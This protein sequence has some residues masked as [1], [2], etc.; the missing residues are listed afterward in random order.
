MALPFAT[1]CHLSQRARAADAVAAPVGH[2][3]GHRAPEFNMLAVGE[4]RSIR[5]ADLLGK[6]VIINFYC[7]CNFCSIVGE[8]WVKN[9]DKVGDVPVLAV[10]SNH[11]NYS[12]SAVKQYRART[13]WPWPILADIGS[14]TTTLFN[15]HTCPKLFVLD[16]QGIIR[17]ASGEGA[18]D[19][20]ALVAA[21]VAAVEAVR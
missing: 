13:G 21:A 1:G 5:S 12:P 11:W 18:A 16:H 3:V 2:Q 20:K 19:E 6:P 14:Q 4:K 7:G 10:M 9:K 17:F 15:A 8:E